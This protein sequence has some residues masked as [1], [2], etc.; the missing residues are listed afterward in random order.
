MKNSLK[1]CGWQTHH[2]EKLLFRA[3]VGNPIIRL[4]FFHYPTY[5]QT[6][7]IDKFPSQ[8]KLKVKGNNSFFLFQHKVRTKGT[9]PLDRIITII[10]IP[11]S[12]DPKSDWGK[13]SS[14]P[15]S[16]QR[17]YQQNSKYWP[18]KSASISDVS[19]QEWFRTDD[20]S[21]WIQSASR[22]VTARIRHR[23]KQEK[24]LG[25]DQAFLR[26][27]GDCDEFTDLF[28][29][30]ARMRGI[31]CRRLTG[32]FIARKGALAEAHAWGEILSPKVGWV[33]TDVALNNIGNHRVNYVIL[34]I[35]EFNPALPDYQILTRHS[36]AVHYQW[37]RPDPIIAPV[38]CELPSEN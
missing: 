33:I 18:V 19:K 35:E 13:I 1:L 36:S 5:R 23:K 16:L 20:I 10:P 14:F 24:R 3:N 28:I 38:Y 7:R 31:P 22:Y 15:R 37:E 30:F 4:K 25:A 12:I 6:V 27:I 29:T 11:S 9:I 2:Q 34:K 26:G 8:C 32:Y 21:H 17:K